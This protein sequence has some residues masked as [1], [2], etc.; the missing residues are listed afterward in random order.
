[1]LGPSFLRFAHSKPT[2]RCERC[3]LRYPEDKQECPHCA[4][5]DGH[6]L[7]LLLRKRKQES[8]AIARMGRFM[9][10]LAAALIVIFAVYGLYKF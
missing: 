2:R 1:M 8:E 4:H 5:L 6:A 7:Q 9:F 10:A 3:G